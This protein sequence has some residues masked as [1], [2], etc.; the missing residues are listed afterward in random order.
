MTLSSTSTVIEYIGLSVYCLWQQVIIFFQVVFVLFCF[1]F[2][3]KMSFFYFFI[4]VTVCFFYKPLKNPFLGTRYPQPNEHTNRQSRTYRV[5]GTKYILCM[6]DDTSKY[7]SQHRMCK[8]KS[9]NN[10]P[11]QYF[12]FHF[13]YYYYV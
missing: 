6:T 13:Y 7:L 11:W 9:I 10:F 8:H 4:S 3:Q 2:S 12:H 1:F 5:V